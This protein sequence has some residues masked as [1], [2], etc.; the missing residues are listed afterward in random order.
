[1][2]ANDWLLPIGFMMLGALGMLGLL[3]ALSWLLGRR[4]RRR[5]QAAGQLERSLDMTV[6][7]VGAVRQALDFK[8]VPHEVLSEREWDFALLVE[9]GK[10]NKEI[11]AA[12]HVSVF[13]VENQLKRIFRKLKVRSRT[14]LARRVREAVAELGPPMKNA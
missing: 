6:A 3:V 11:A 12:L 4:S 7:A 9:R 1:M 8:P 2:S 10:S 13:T 5:A 14:E